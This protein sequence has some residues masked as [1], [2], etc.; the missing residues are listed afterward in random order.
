MHRPSILWLEDNGKDR[1]LIQEALRE[2]PDAPAVEFVD[3]GQ[4]FLDRLTETKPDLAVLDLRMPGLD[5]MDILEHMHGHP[6]VARLP[7]VVFS[8]GDAPGPI[9]SEHRYPVLD[10]VRKPGTL[11]EFQAA[12]A[13]IAEHARP[14]SS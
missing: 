3:D 11:T 12:I 8:A 13:R 5:G 2:L 10:Y 4:A 9:V 1:R 14:P 6:I 7:V